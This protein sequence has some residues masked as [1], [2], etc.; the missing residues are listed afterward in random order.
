MKKRA[1]LIEQAGVILGAI[2]IVIM[3]ANSSERPVTAA[4]FMVTGILMA[5]IG[6][7]LTGTMSWL[8]GATLVAILIAV[9]LYFFTDNNKLYNLF[10]VIGVLLL[11]AEF[12][13]KSK[14][15][16]KSNST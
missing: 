11:I 10:L 8:G 14:K 5:I 1:G 4:A 16:K 9:I 13:M 15:Q 6:G 3:F 12:I 7:R 2:G